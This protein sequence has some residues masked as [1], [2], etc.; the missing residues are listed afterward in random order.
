MG[1]V[2]PEASGRPARLDLLLA[3]LLALAATLLFYRLGAHPLMETSDARYA[4]IAWE[5][6]HTGDWLTPRMDFALHLDKPPLA[7]WLGALGLRLLGHSE[8]AVRLPLALAALLCLLI[9]HRTARR[10][11]GLRA[12]LAAALILATA[13]LFFFMARLF[14]TDLYLTLFVTAA[15]AC[16]L[17]GYAEPRPPLVWRL[18]F[19]L[20]LALAFLTKGPV[21]LLHTLLPIA[22]Y[23]LLWGARGRLAPFLGPLPLLLFVAVAAPWFVAVGLRH[24]Q[25]ASFYLNHELLARL[26]GNAL[27]RAQPVYYFA[28]ILAGGLAPWSVWLAG[29]LGRGREAPW[30]P[31]AAVPHLDRLLACWLWIPFAILSLVRSKLPPYVLPLF[32]AAA[33][34]GGG[35]AAAWLTRPRR[36]GWW[37]P[38][39]VAAATAA[40]VAA[41][42]AF[43]RE[44]AATWPPQT[45]RAVRLAFWAAVACLLAVAASLRRPS[46][47]AT[48][49]ALAAFALCLDLAGIHYLP[50]SKPH[51]RYHRLARQLAAAL[52]PEDRGVCFG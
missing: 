21:A 36:P 17:R 37:R 9:L 12:A 38:L 15:Y 11:L 2:S 32:P 42:I 6:V 45:E 22:T 44:R 47:G 26:H 3:A 16:L 10:L 51:H 30:G 1:A 24:P 8:F 4:E 40:L 43:H 5:M 39:L 20:A 33:L 35:V 29:H 25:L 13:P 27:H 31:E 52:A 7:Y 48:F 34:W 50:V 41:G 46:R 18:G 14:T 19:A 23:H 28:G 49:A